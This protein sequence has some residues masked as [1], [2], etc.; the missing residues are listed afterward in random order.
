M[1]YSFFGT[2][3]NDYDQ[4][5][6][7]LKTILN[8]TILP[9]EIIIVNA[10]ELDVEKEIFNLI[11]SKNIK[12]VYILKNISRVKSLNIALAQSTAK[13]SFR[14]D[15]RSR[16]GANYAKNALKI[17]NSNLIS[18]QVVG[19]VPEIKS[20]SNKLEALICASIMSRPYV[21]CFP[22]HRN[23]NYVGYSSSI[24]LG[25]FNSKLLKKIRFNEQSSHLSEDSQIIN[26]FLDMGF[27]SY[28]SS[29][30]KLSYICRSSFKNLLKLFNT[31]GFCRANT[32]LVTKKIFISARHFFAF[33]LS[34]ILVLLL[35][36]FNYSYLLFLPI[37]LLLFNL[38]SEIIFSRKVFKLYIPFYATLCQFSWILG[39]IWRLLTILKT[40]KLKSNFIS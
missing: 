14:F 15:T 30:I 13:Y 9:K 17:L 34:I 23:I 24:Y 18:A 36:I 33:F 38:I 40:N 32:I 28:I 25:C 8:Q 6:G 31:Y 2:C 19:G 16:F 26:D 12:L 4:L 22:K 10:G 27:K 39:F 37:V 35:I 1:S 11:D 20:D 3:Y 21:F 29:D 7:C 5:F